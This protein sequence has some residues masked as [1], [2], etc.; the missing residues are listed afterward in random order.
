MSAKC[1]IRKHGEKSIEVILKELN[2]LDKGVKEGN[3][4][5]ISQDL[6][7]LTS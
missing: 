6:S 2:Q 1:G 3:P 7:K 5:V 4:V